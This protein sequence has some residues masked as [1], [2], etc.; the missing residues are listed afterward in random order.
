MGLDRAPD[1]PQGRVSPSW[2][3]V[4][5]FRRVR[6]R[7]SF[8]QYSLARSADGKGWFDCPVFRRSAGATRKS[9]ECAEKKPYPVPYRAFCELR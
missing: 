4:A 3:T 9:S 5:R 8:N 2:A 6:T 1:C 7:K